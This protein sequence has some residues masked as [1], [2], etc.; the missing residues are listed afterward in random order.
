MGWLPKEFYSKEDYYFIKNNPDLNKAE[1]GYVGTALSYNG[2]WFSGYTGIVKTKDGF[3]DYQKEAYLNL[4]NQLPRIEGIDFRHCSYAD[5]QIPDKS[6]IYC[7]PPYEQTTGYKHR[8]DSAFF[9]DWCRA[10]T[11]QGHSVFISEYQAPYDF[12]A[13]WEKSLKSSLSTKS[14]SSTEKL[15]IY[16]PLLT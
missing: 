9:W 8:F 11:L 13:V 2:K 16:E 1:T 5:L 12:I 4:L 6:I 14:K 10:K 7:D 3:R 15:F